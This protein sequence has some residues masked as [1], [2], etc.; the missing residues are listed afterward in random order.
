MLAA[1]AELGGMLAP[2]ADPTASRAG[3]RQLP[4]G[5]SHK[6]SHQAQ[7]VANNP[8]ITD[9]TAV[10]TQKTINPKPSEITP[11]KNNSGRLIYFLPSFLLC[12]IMDFIYNKRRSL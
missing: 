11:L 4:N 12:F 1:E 5:I 7:A 6:E 3:R 2:L 9:E 10:H 8:E